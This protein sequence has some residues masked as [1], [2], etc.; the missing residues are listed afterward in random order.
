LLPPLD[1]ISIAEASRRAHLRDVATVAASFHA[2]P[3]VDVHE[4]MEEAPVLP[5]RLP[6]AI[7]RPPLTKLSADE[8]GR[9]RRAPIAAGSM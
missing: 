6:R 9:T 8:I 3:A 1:D 7:L 2:D 4:R 5:G